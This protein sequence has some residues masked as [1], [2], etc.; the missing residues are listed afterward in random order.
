MAEVDP[1]TNFPQPN[2][3]V[4]WQTATNEVYMKWGKPE[5][6][7][8][9]Q[10]RHYQLEC[11]KIGNETGNDGLK[12]QVLTQISGNDME[13]AATHYTAKVREPG[14]YAFKIFAVYTSGKSQSQNFSFDVRQIADVP[15]KMLMQAVAGSGQ[16][17]GRHTVYH[18]GKD[19]KI[20]I[21]KGITK[22]NVQVP[23]DSEIGNAQEKVILLA[24]ETGSG[25][26][27]LINFIVN[28]LYGIEF[29]D[30]FRFKLIDDN[31]EIKEAKK[32]AEKVDSRSLVKWFKKLTVGRKECDSATQLVSCYTMKPVYGTKFPY[33]VH[34]VDT[35]GYADTQGKEKD[36]WTTEQIRNFFLSDEHLGI[37]H[38]DA[39][40]LVVRASTNRLNDAQKYIFDS[41]MTLFGKD[42]AEN[43]F[44]FCTHA[45]GKKPKVLNAIEKHGIPY[46]AS[47][48]FSNGVLYDDE[49][50]ADGG[51]DDAHEAIE[52]NMG[53]KSCENFFLALHDLPSKSLSE[54]QDV[55]RRRRQLEECIQYFIRYMD[56]LIL[57]HHAS[58][59]LKIDLES[60]GDIENQSIDVELISRVKRESKKCMNC[61]YCERTCHEDCSVWWN[62]LNW[63]CVIMEGGECTNCGCDV[64]NHTSEEFI[65]TN[66]KRT[67]TK[68]VSELLENHEQMGSNKEL[69]AAQAKHDKL[70]EK[71]L[72]LQKVQR[73]IDELENKMEVQL[74]KAMAAQ[75]KLH[76]IALKPCVPSGVDFI[77][78]LITQMK[79]ERK[80][81]WEIKVDVLENIKKTLFQQ[82]TD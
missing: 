52:W 42:I 49:D 15:S 48:K 45:D 59:K 32:A 55:S 19:R 61:N 37:P 62:W 43:I 51:N 72:L 81:N 14:K 63:T 58:E 36:Q 56:E 76:E 78:N 70:G 34:I 44:I 35:P 64:G 8:E 29:Q 10:F 9:A 66:E 12:W 38:I 18:L 25:K 2:D 30:K 23:K 50:D 13:T 60:M 77:G 31:E 24:G 26:T 22:C 73:E 41:V 5:R 39:V 20:D 71:A 7:R 40:A 16:T 74:Q 75:V 47:Y 28:Q 33:T 27:T 80:E 54:T 69:K 6:R 11:T 57:K 1:G 3:F 79:T 4:V 82:M 46:R 68:K 65:W 17:L 53:K 67:V 21:S